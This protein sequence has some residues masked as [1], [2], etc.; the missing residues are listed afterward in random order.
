M[1]QFDRWHHIQPVA[2]VAL[3]A[4]AGF[5]AKAPEGVR[6]LILRAA[7]VFHRPGGLRVG[8]R[9]W[10][11]FGSRRLI[12][13]NGLRKILNVSPK[14]CGISLCR[15]AARRRGKDRMKSIFGE[16]ETEWRW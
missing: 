2:D 7:R 4:A 5:S 3:Y 9:S 8:A 6:F 14:L 11:R 13:R 1:A 15:Q 10:R 12:R 16:G